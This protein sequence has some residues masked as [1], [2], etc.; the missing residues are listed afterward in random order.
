MFGLFKKK[1]NKDNSTAGHRT[2]KTQSSA[3]PQGPWV[4][5]EALMDQGRIAEALDHFA[6]AA[7]QTRDLSHMDLAERWLNDQPLLDKA[8]EAAVCRFVALL[9]QVLD[10][11]EPVQRGRMWNACLKAL[12]ALGDDTAPRQD[13]T[14]R[15]TTECILLRHMGR[16]EEGLKAAQE[17]IA[18]HKA[19]S[20]YTF[21][22][23]CCLDM[24]DT[25]GAEDH[26]LQGLEQDP[27][28]LAP[29]NDLADYFLNH[30]MLDKAIEYYA[31]VV[32]RGDAQD[33][34][35]AEPSLIFSRWLVSRDPVELE[36]LAL[37]A[38]S[39]PRNQRAAQLRS[40]VRQ[41]KA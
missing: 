10:P 20:C 30:Q 1:D 28:N 13:M 35:W 37:Y 2:E 27:K 19:A 29:C 11:M 22:G 38:A 41:M 24:G 26:V 4:Q 9:T 34:E 31:M 7:I 18:R 21:A 15:Y 16:L 36:R 17:G 39:Q 6:R 8:G 25:K 5:A 23:L 40:A 32:D 3:Q 33:I 12:R 14:D